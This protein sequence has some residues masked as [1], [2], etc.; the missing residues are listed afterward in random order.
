[1]VERTDQNIAYREY[2][3]VCI[4][5]RF[6]LR[7]S[8]GIKLIAELARSDASDEDIVKAAN[9]LRRIRPGTR[10]THSGGT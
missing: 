2:L 3:L 10:G 6:D 1:M 4:K 9:A 8:L 7:G 5:G